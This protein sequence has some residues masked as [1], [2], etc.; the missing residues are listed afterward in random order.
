MLC[1]RFRRIACSTGQKALG[2]GVI[3]FPTVTAQN[4]IIINASGYTDIQTHAHM[5]FIQRAC[6]HACISTN[7]CE[8]ARIERQRE[9][10]PNG[11]E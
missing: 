10:L 4:T 7:A 2:S 8:R 11:L 6:T 5:N 3:D 9:R 1:I